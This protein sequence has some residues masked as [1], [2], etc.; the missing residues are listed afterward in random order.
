MTLKQH[1]IEIDNSTMNNILNEDP[2]IIIQ[3][4][5]SWKS[6]FRI[7]RN[8]TFI[9]IEVG[10]SEQTHFVALPQE[11]RNE[12]FLKYLYFEL[13]GSQKETICLLT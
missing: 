6:S 1:I 11:L 7:K 9:S 13:G 8:S 12:F 10:S 3:Y 2:F 4:H 5:R